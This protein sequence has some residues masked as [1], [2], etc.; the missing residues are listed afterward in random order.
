[1]KIEHIEIRGLN[2]RLTARYDLQPDINVVTGLNGSGKT[3]LIKVMWYLISGNAER[4]AREVNFE[5]LKV[6]TNRFEVQIERKGEA[7]SWKFVRGND[8]KEGKYTLKDNPSRGSQ[9]DIL[10]RMIVEEPGT[11]LYFPTFRRIEGGYSMTGLHRVRH[12]AP[13]AIYYADIHRQDG[14][15]RELESLADRISVNDHKFICSIST[16]DIV[17]LLTQRYASV[18]E[19]LNSEYKSFSTSIIETINAAKA[20]GQ[21]S[22]ARDAP[23]VLNS[24]QDR[25]DAINQRREELLRPFAVLSELTAKLFR[26]KGISVQAVTLG[27]SAGAIDSGLLS[28]G[29]KQMLSF[30][31]YNAFSQDAVVFIDEPELSLHPDWQRRLF[32]ILLRQQ[33]SNQFVVAT[34]SPFIY[35]KYEDKEIALTEEKGE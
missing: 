10:N 18:S 9:V 22:V 29:E 8:T 4:I 32:G 12:V 13:D 14:I 31:C 30:L 21:E 1:M 2:K 7:F 34:H 23:N 5:L 6:R 19:A 16:D 24:I 11:S 35:T 26:H 25:A 17:S 15:Q 27:E 33:P 20:K 28:A 3:S